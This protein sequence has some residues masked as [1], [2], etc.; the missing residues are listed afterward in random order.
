MHKI[1]CWQDIFVEDDRRD[2]A[3]LILRLERQE[4]FAVNVVEKLADKFSLTGEERAELLPSGK[5]TR[6]TNR[7]HW[8]KSYLKQAELVSS[9]RRGYFVITDK[10]R[11][12]LANTSIVINNAF[13]EQFPGYQDFKNRTRDADVGSTSSLLELQESVTQPA[14]PDETLREAHRKITAT[15]NPPGK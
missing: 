5:Q 6:F 3:N 11:A 7:V 1:W 10:G 4:L 8:A 12:A 15:G 13:L 2:D 9:T 14:T